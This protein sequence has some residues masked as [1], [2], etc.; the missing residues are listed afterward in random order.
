MRKIALW[1]M[2]GVMLVSLAGCSEKATETQEVIV[3][4]AMMELPDNVE[5]PEGYPSKS[6]EIIV[7]AAAGG[8]AD[9][10]ARALEANADFGGSAVVVNLAGGNQTIGTSEVY[11]RDP[12][13]CTLLAVPT[14]GLC[15]QP[16][17]TE[18]DYSA[19]DFRYLTTFTMPS[20]NGMFVRSDSGIETVEDLI[21]AL[22]TGELDYASPAVGSIGQLSAQ[23]FIKDVEGSATHVAYSGNNEVATALLGGHIDLAVVAPSDMKSYVDAGQFRCLVMLSNERIDNY[24]EVP[25]C[26]E[27]GYEGYEGFSQVSLLAIHKDTPPET[28]NWIKQQ[29]YAGIASQGYQDFLKAANTATPYTTAN[30]E[31][32]ITDI[33]MNGDKMYAEL[34]SE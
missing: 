29:V 16:H 27:L 23:Q 2:C 1:V 7:P 8:T 20:Y 10:M 4:A 25:C 30:S 18:V 17:L 9:L 5:K 24:P 34:L 13:G 12:D 11:N 32:Y 19:E 14:V 28:V 33:I 31:A 15:V 21:A 6:I 3:D 22:K 26:E